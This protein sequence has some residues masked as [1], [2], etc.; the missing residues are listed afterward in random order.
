MLTIAGNKIYSQYDNVVSSKRCFIGKPRCLRVAGKKNKILINLQLTK[1][2][3]LFLILVY[4]C[5]VFVLMHVN[6]IVCKM[7]N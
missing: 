5:I 3:K 1:S 7:K 2:C 4:S 6:A